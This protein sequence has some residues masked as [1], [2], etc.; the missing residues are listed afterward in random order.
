[1]TL[2]PNL[3]IDRRVLKRRLRLWQALSVLAVILL[4]F[5]Y[6]DATNDIFTKDKV[7]RLQINGMIVEDP[8]RD[9]ILADIKKD[10][11]VRA[12]IVTINSP[13]GTVVGGEDLYRS[14]TSVGEKKPVVSIMGTVATSAAYMAA[15]AGDKLFAR[16]STITGS[17]GVVYQT[18]DLTGMLKKIGVVPESLKSGP[19]K[20]VPSPLEPLTDTG[21]EATQILVKDLFRYFVDLISKR[22]PI[23]RAK[24][25]ELADGRVFTGRQALEN[26]LIDSIGNISAARDWLHEE[27]GI[28]KSLPIIDIGT[29]SKGWNLSKLIFGLNKKSLFPNS[30]ALD[31][32]LSVW[33]PDK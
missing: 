19:L 4:V 6:L 10:N 29:E 30:I 12:L 5:F 16:E 32:L 13:G 9:V 25:L 14:L 3:L 24:I 28:P 18:I 15:I 22:R 7:A 11:S 27:K 1:M 23:D 21:R 2:D 26:G 20:A 17:I 31:G 8:K 33:Q